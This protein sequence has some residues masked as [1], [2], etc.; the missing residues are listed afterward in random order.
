MLFYLPTR[1]QNVADMMYSYP[2]EWK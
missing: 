1:K 2:M